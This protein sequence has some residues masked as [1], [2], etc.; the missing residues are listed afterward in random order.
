MSEA[1]LLLVDDDVAHL[2]A[3][4]ERLSG[5]GFE[6]AKASSGRVPGRTS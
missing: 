3:L 2:D 4:A 5:D 1:R 6:V